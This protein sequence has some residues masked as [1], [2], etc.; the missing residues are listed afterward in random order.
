MSICPIMSHRTQNYEV[1][2]TP[3]CEWYN[4]HLKG[5]HVSSFVI[6]ANKFMLMMSQ[7]QDKPEKKVM[8]TRKDYAE[9]YAGMSEE[10]KQAEVFRHGQK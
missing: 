7:S 6:N 1:L 4:R 8:P 3:E 10:E 2:C 5:C 9:K